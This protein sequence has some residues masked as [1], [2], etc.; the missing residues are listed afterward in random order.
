[1]DK[2]IEAGEVL[3]QAYRD[4]YGIT[5][6]P[7]VDIRPGHFGDKSYPEILTEIAQASGNY[8]KVS[9]AVELMLRAN[10][11]DNKRTIRANVYAALQRNRKRFIKIS[12]GEY[13]YTNHVEKPSGPSGL[14][15]VI[16][17]LKDKNPQMTKRE[18]LNTLLRSGFDFKGK[19]PVNA[20]NITW[21]Y[22]SYSKEG[23][24]QS[25]LR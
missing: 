7:L 22:L 19:K 17:E 3:L 24:Q 5:S 21:A 25:L 4:K 9:D 6:L 23:K 18:V 16:K 11:S 10:V 2:K 14:R 13:R 8:L 15:Q 12:P 20:V 1:M